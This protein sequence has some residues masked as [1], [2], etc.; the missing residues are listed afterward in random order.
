MLFETALVCLVE[1][2]GWRN[3]FFIFIFLL[4]NTSAACQD[5]EKDLINLNI[6]CDSQ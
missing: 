6:E 1:L 2:D 3:L 4:N 5:S